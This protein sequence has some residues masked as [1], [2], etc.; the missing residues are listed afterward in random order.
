MAKKYKSI[1]YIPY[2]HN[3]KIICYYELEFKK[4]IIKP[5]EIIKFKSER[6]SFKFY[7]WVH[8]TELNV[9]WIDCLEV[10]AG[11]FRSLPIDNLKGILRP[12]K[13]RRKKHDVTD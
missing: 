12:K 1:D 6:G 8:N 7:R 2:F 10:G 4:D 3:D 9:Q 13:S 11:T 5:G